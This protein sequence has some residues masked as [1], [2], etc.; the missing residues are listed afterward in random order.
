M[1][2]GRP[3]LDHNDQTVGVHIKLPSR[4]Y[5]EACQQAKQQRVS[6]PEYI[7]RALKAADKNLDT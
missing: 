4:Q 2:R 5:D 3:R 6:L 1:K 7:R